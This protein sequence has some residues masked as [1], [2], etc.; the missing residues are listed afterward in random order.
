M[1]SS[2][3]TDAIA[4]EIEQLK[5]K[6]H[7]EPEDVWIKTENFIDPNFKA[8]E[9]LKHSFDKNSNG[10]PMSIGI[11]QN[12]DNTTSV[13]YYASLFD[14]QMG[15]DMLIK[16]DINTA[17]QL[18]EKSIAHSAQDP[19]ANTYSFEKHLES[20]VK[21]FEMHHETEI[22]NPHDLTAQLETAKKTGYVQGVCECVAAIGDDHTLGKKLLSEMNVTKYMAK[23]FASPETYKALENG[24][25][26]QKQEQKQ[27]QTHKIKH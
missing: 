12:D 24:I 2:T 23:K 20:E 21:K 26:A 13:Y 5:S 6:L 11:T 4:A 1:A 19:Y 7:Y 10:N 14:N 15:R 8:E 3:L 22:K 27:E 9:I 25:F 17:R 18:I 16:G